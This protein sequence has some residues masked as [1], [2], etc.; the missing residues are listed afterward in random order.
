MAQNGLL[1]LK[2]GSYG[3]FL[4]HGSE[5]SGSKRDGISWLANHPITFLRTLSSVS[6]RKGCR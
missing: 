3:I 2:T 5:I 6:C 4:R 1:W